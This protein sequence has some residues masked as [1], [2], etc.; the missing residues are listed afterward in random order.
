MFKERFRGLPG[1]RE[2]AEVGEEYRVTILDGKKPHVDLIPK[3]P[4]AI[5]MLL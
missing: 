4:A 2:E 3:D 5:G 1:T